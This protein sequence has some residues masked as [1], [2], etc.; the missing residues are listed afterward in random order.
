VI[1]APENSYNGQT[2]GCSQTE[3]EK[4]IK[5]PLCLHNELGIF[6]EWVNGISAY[7]AKHHRI[8]IG[9]SSFDR[10]PFAGPDKPPSVADAARRT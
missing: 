8:Y 6:T 3:M 2:F 10:F 5:I 1:V 4:Q 7:E 9:P